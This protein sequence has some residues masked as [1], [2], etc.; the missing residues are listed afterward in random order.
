VTEGL[1]PAF[2]A[3]THGT[4]TSGL[5]VSEFA[6]IRSAG[7]EPVGQVLGSTVHNLGWFYQTPADCGYRG[8]LFTTG[9]SQTVT[10]AMSRGLSTYVRTIYEARRVAM[11]RMAAECAAL[12][13]DGVVAVQ[14]DIKPF[15]AAQ[16]MLE[17]QAFGTAVRAL[18]PERPARP[19]LS[20]LTGQEF[21]KL[22]MAGWV[23]VDMALGMSAGVRHDDWTTVMM[24]GGINRLSPVTYGNV[25]VAGWTELV[26][27][28]RHESRELLLR[29]SARTGAEGVVLSDSRL[30][31]HER[32]CGY[33]GEDSH[34]HVVE[35]TLIGTSIVSF[36][37]SAAP[38][39]ALTIMRLK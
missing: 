36:T 28:T 22:L 12:G 31:V 23:P 38:P 2:A 14:L 8:G 7:F 37:K 5:S 25:E 24:S 3:R 10:S 11:G 13:G 32:A 15:P 16:G 39:R 21:A 20:H 30:T 29:D 35:S 19:F 4:W 17:F 6:A 18:G 34:D 9:I 27:V 33:G 26:N 1:P